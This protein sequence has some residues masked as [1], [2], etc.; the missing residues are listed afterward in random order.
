MTIAIRGL[1]SL[2]RIGIKDTVLSKSIPLYG[3]MIHNIDGSTYPVPYGV[4]DQA[5]YSISRTEINKLLILPAESHPPVQG[6]LEHKLEKVYIK[7]NVVR[8]AGVGQK[9][10]ECL[11]SAD[12]SYSKTRAQ[13]L[14]DT[15]FNYSQ[16]YIDALYIELSILP[17][18]E[19][20]SKMPLNYLHVW[21]RGN[22]MLLGLPNQDMSW[23]MTLFG[24]KSI[25]NELQTKEGVL[26][27]F[28]KYFPDAIELI[29]E[30]RILELCLGKKGYPMVSV[31][32]S[33]HVINS[34]I[35][36]KTFFPARL[37]AE[38]IRPDAFLL[39][40]RI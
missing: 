3:R 18:K 38:G 34:T 2:E 37:N 39:K 29:E 19:G 7:E 5:V 4:K 32:C 35:E 9:V 8:F 13:F 28:T 15:S 21:P 22:F 25:Y 10:I 14:R 40:L 6:H 30:A 23:T 26:G 36:S 31:K 27:V 16:E 11:V 20:K 33:P 1:D 24:P 17:N 12:G